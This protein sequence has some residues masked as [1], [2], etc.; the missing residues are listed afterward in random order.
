MVMLEQPDELNRKIKRF[1]ET[2][3]QASRP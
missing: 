2:L 3:D 1:L